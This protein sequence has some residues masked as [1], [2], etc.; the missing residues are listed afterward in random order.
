MV[1]RDYAKLYYASARTLH[2]D[3]GRSLQGKLKAILRKLKLASVFSEREMVPIKMHLGNPG[4]HRTIPPLFVREVVDELKEVGA[5][6]FVTDS[7]RL[8]GYV[9]LEHAYKSGYNPMTFGCPVTIADGLAGN[10]SIKVKAGKHLK[11]LSIPSA[12]HDAKGMIVLTHVTGHVAYGYGGALK[13][14]AM[15]CISQ[16]CRGE[17]WRDGDRGRMH[18]FGGREIQKFPAKC[19]HCGACMEICPTESISFAKKGVMIRKETCF[20]CARCAHVCKYGALTVDEYGADY[21]EVLAEAAKAVVKTFDDGRI[22]HINFMLN[23]QPECDCMPMCDTPVVQDLGILAGTDC[24]AIDMATLDLVGSATPLPGS[25]AEDMTNS[26]ENDVFSQVNNRT[27]RVTLKYGAKIGIGT[28][29]Y[30]LTEV[31]GMPRKRK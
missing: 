28:T 8:P 9:Y 12:I 16:K 23:M 20:N 14:L 11:Q 1:R 5:R 29:N 19:I 15:G 26:P 25:R 24:I 17:N 10:D 27:P 21:Y 18:T 13:N 30:K 22:I 7:A 6:P 3:T 2:F 4:V 31:K